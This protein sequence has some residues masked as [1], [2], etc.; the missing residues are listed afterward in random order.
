[1]GLFH[2]HDYPR[3]NDTIGLVE[4]DGEEV[5]GTV[6]RNVQV[7]D[8]WTCGCGKQFFVF[9]MKYGGKGEEFPQWREAGKFK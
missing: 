4:V 2:K 8:D 7:G 5:V 1:M 9:T 3:A 6:A